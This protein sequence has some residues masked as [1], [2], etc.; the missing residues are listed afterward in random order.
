M[1]MR[2]KMLSPKLFVLALMM[3]F[4]VAG[5]LA[6]VGAAPSPGWDIQTVDSEEDVGRCTSIALDSSNNPHISYLDW[7][8][9]LKYARWTGSSW[10]IAQR[11]LY[12]P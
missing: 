10:S 5:L 6:F 3:I 9:N 4:A 2:T 1:V 11:A 12:S 8:E 7:I